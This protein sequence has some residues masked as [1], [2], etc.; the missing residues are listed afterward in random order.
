MAMYK[1]GRCGTIIKD[2]DKFCNNCGVPIM[3]PQN[4]VQNMQQ[5]QVQNQQ[6]IKKTESALSAVACVFGLIAVIDILFIGIFWYL[7]GPVSFILGLIDLCMNN[8]SKKHGGSIFG[9]VLGIIMVLFII[10]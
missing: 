3:L 5:Y 7:L 9:V 8:K 6:Q 4:Q 1:C 10:F 2:T